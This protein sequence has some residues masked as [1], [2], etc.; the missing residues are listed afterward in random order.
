MT[1]VSATK[2]KRCEMLKYSVAIMVIGA[3]VVGM[4]C[5]DNEQSF[6]IEHAKSPP[7]PP[8]C[9]TSEGDPFTTSGGTDLAVAG[10]Y[11][12]TFLV[13]NGM[14][15]KENYANLQA[16]TNGIFIEGA[17]TN[18]ESV[19]GELIGET[20][21]YDQPIWVEPE[22][23]GLASAILIGGAEAQ[24]LSDGYGCL[25]VSRSNYP[26][27][28][29]GGTDVNGQAVGRYFEPVYANIRF[30]GH[31]NGG[32]DVET[33]VIRFLVELCCGC[34]V[35]WSTCAD[36]C[37]AFCNVA[38]DE[39]CSAGKFGGGNYPCGNIYFDSSATWQGNC[40]DDE[41]NPIDCDC[42]TCN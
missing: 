5:V 30:L 42:S 29:L 17:E 3:C 22:G 36:P 35:D 31:T 15:A 38:E 20:V 32:L 4:G 39:F 9:V 41:G 23:E 16:E 14:V 8:E 10:S 28:T 37:E 2:D 26:Y 21:Y 27:A 1:R 25:P 12:L 33:P 11:G 40:E 34:M 7:E 18:L 24:A 19:G 6:F 13:Q